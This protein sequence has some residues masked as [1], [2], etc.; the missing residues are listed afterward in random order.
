MA[1][2]I[3]HGKQHDPGTGLPSSY[4]SRPLDR[5]KMNLLP[6]NEIIDMAHLAFFQMQ[7]TDPEVQALGVAV[8]FTVCMKVS[9]LDPEDMVNRA[10]RV[11]NAPYHGDHKTSASLQSLKDLLSIRMMGRDTSFW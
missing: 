2:T 5:D 11:L 7:D 3:R 4:L 10:N 1:V 8:L 6:R 9:G